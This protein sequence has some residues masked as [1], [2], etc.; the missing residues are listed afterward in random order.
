MSA[1]RR[2]PSS[3]PRRAARNPVFWLAAF[4]ALG[5]QLLFPAGFMAAEPGQA[6]GLPIVICTAQ[7]QTIADWDALSAPDGGHKKAPPKSM[8]G[9]PFAGHAVAAD[10]PAPA[11]LVRPV[12]F[13]AAPAPSRPYLVAPGR[14]LAAPPP[15]AIGPPL[16]A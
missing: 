4:L 3:W 1:A 2:S 13:D 12:V 14:G 10:P 11:A 8:A 16:S 9:C 7:G 15:P 6:R 5:L